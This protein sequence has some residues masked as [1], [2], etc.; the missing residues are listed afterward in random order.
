MLG[1]DQLALMKTTA[2]LIVVSRGG[3][4][5]E[6][7]L[8]KMLKEGRLAGAGFDVA[9]QEPLPPEDPLWDAPNMVI[10]PHCSG[11]SRQTGEASWAVFKGNLARFVAGEPL[12][13][14]VDKRRGY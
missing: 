5:H 2:Y 10:T 11:L 1:P 12:L 4:V 8:A 3:I 7:T 6:P 13:T 14:P 9:E